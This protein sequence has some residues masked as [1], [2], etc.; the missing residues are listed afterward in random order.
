MSCKIM[1]VNTPGNYDIWSI[2]RWRT[3]GSPYKLQ[4]HLEAAGYYYT[5]PFIGVLPINIPPQTQ[6]VCPQLAH[7]YSEL[8]VFWEAAAG[9]ATG[10]WIS[11]FIPRISGLVRS[12]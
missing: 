4:F 6:T 9:M 8:R 5:T 7:I 11:F 2:S 10:S 3:S 1:S 12:K